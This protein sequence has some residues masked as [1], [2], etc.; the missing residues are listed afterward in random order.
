VHKVVVEKRQKI[1]DFIR[2]NK[3]KDC[4]STFKE[5]DSGKVVFSIKPANLA[6]QDSLIGPTDDK[7]PSKTMTLDLSGTKIGK[8]P[9]MKLSHYDIYKIQN[10][11]R[12]ESKKK[13]RLKTR[14]QS[15]TL[16][17]QRKCCQVKS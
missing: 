17:A 12:Y 13:K 1:P 9:A 14:S 16:E 10:S 2:L 3:S 15:Q 4:V 5:N 7:K 11:A 6:L 8:F